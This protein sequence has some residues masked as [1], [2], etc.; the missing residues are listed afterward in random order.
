[1]ELRLLVGPWT[2]ATRAHVR[3][4]VQ[5]FVQTVLGY[6]VDQA[7]AAEEL[8]VVLVE[9]LQPREPELVD[10]QDLRGPVPSLEPERPT[11]LLDDHVLDLFARR[12]VRHEG[13]IVELAYRVHMGHRLRR[14]RL[15]T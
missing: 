5:V 1:P 14:I 8:V 13:Q 9:S 7:N 6:R 2:G 10:V 12:V 4:L 15:R 3:I 11:P